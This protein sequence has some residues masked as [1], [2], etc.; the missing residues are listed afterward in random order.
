M[1]DFDDILNATRQSRPLSRAEQ[2][3]EQKILAEA[4]SRAELSE[5]EKKSQEVWD[6]VDRLLPKL[7]QSVAPDAAVLDGHYI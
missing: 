4:E 1:A 7:K 2:A 5:R 6:I 3:A